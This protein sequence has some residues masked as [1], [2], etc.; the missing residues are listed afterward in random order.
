MPRLV[1]DIWDTLTG[2][3]HH[4]PEILETANQFIEWSSR[5]YHQQFMDWLFDEYDKPVPIKG[6]QVDLIIGTARANAFKEIRRYLQ[7][8]ESR[9]NSALNREQHGT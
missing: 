3:D 5:P 2:H 7:D 4:E 8:E 6:N 1:Q 9:A